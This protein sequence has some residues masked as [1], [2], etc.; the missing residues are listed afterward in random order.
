MKATLIL[1]MLCLAA[2]AFAGSGGGL[3][4]NYLPASPETPAPASTPPGPATSS[5]APNKREGEQSQIETFV[6]S[7]LPSII[8]AEH[9][10]A[11]SLDFLKDKVTYFETLKKQ[12]EAAKDGPDTLATIKKLDPSDITI[13]TV[14]NEARVNV[15]GNLVSEGSSLPTLWVVSIK[16]SPSA[17]QPYAISQILAAKL[18]G[19]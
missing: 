16:I 9:G 11:S 5:P 2:A 13:D 10:D 3:K 17:A 4:P 12:C 1:G 7:V 18:P 15:I 8:A 19:T 14:K 6:R